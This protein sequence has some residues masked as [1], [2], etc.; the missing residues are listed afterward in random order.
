MINPYKFPNSA[1]Y[2]ISVTGTAA[3]L[4]DLI[5]TAASASIAF[6]YSLNWVE[7]TPEDGAI[8]YTD[9]GTAPTATNGNIIVD[10]ERREFQTAPVNVKLISVTGT[11]TCN[12]R[13]GWEHKG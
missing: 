10:D 12:V 2:K 4:L 1:A 9:N 8:R 7:I 13:V 5:E 6:P 11:V 3:N